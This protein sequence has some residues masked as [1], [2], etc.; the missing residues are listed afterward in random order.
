MTPITTTN[1]H[2]I[3]QINKKIIMYLQERVR[4]KKALY[5]SQIGKVI[6]PQTTVNRP[7]A[8]REVEQ[9]VMFGLGKDVVQ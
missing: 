8:R 6:L 2:E 4:Q 1:S 3:S 9:N 7:T 5:L